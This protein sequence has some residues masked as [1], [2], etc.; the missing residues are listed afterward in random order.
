[1]IEQAPALDR[2]WHLGQN[3]EELISAGFEYALMR[4]IESFN[5]WQQECLAAVAG[6][7]VSATDNVVLHITR[8]NDRP[9]S[10]TELSKLM[11]RSDLSNLKY[12]IRKL[13]EAGLL[14]K[15]SEGG[16][17]VPGHRRRYQADRG[18]R[19]PAPRTTHA[20]GGGHGR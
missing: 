12:S 19:S 14:E 11:N 9:K 4:C 13:V 20:P 6:H 17:A 16:N 10:V 8:M 3:Q 1:M 5:D 18:L 7:K 2:H 15:V